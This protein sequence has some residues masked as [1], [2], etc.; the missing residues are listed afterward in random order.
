MVRVMAQGQ[1]VLLVGPDHARLFLDLLRLAPLL[2][3]LLPTPLGQLL[4]TVTH[5]WDNLMRA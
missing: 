5:I 3:V 1:C 4:A 2:Q